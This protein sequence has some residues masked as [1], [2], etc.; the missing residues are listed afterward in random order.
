MRKHEMYVP[1]TKI[2]LIN[3]HNKL[4]NQVYKEL[5]PNIRKKLGNKDHS[6]DFIALFGSRAKNSYAWNSDIDIV[7]VSDSFS[8]LRYLDRTSLFETTNFDRQIDFLCF[9]PSEIWKAFQERSSTILT[10]MRDGIVLFSHSQLWKLLQ[11]EFKL[12]PDKITAL[13]K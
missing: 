8:S 6:I 5:I 13:L 7:I 10:L 1:K 2:D 11:I 3:H 9:T 12:V 4:M